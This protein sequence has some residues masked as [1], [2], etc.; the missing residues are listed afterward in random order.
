MSSYLKLLEYVGTLVVGLV[1]YL[2]R[3]VGI[4]SVTERRGLLW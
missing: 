4:K 2:V 3:V 1:L